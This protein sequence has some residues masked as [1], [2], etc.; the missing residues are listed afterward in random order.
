MLVLSGTKRRGPGSY[1]REVASS[2]SDGCAGA[3]GCECH[4]S[5]AAPRGLHAGGWHRRA[6][7]S[8]MADLASGGRAA[9]TVMLPRLRGWMAYDGMEGCI[10]RVRVVLLVVVGEDN[11]FLCRRNLPFI[12][13]DVVSL[14]PKAS[15]SSSG[16]GLKTTKG[17]KEGGNWRHRE[18]SRGTGENGEGEG[19]SG[20]NG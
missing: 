1:V 15:G 16:L 18:T 12:D 17:T 4:G 6:W 20:G 11:D 14:I 10:D 9:T 13:D 8:G 7:G 2:V 3:C 19:K 5:G